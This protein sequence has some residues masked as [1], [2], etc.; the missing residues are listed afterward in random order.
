MIHRTFS[1]TPE[2][3][4][5]FTRGNSNMLPSILYRTFYEISATLSSRVS[6]DTHV[7][8]RENEGLRLRE[9][10]AFQ[11][12]GEVKFENNLTKEGIER[13][14]VWNKKL[15]PSTWIS[16]FDKW[17]MFIHLTGIPSRLTPSRACR[18]TRKVPL[19]RE[20]ENRTTRHRCDDQYGRL[21]RCDSPCRMRIDMGNP[22]EAKVLR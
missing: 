1:E 11:T 20:Q 19:Q 18:T 7:R 12:V 5:A 2:Q 13:H 4:R 14:L 10:N 17:G 9:G 21:H 15:N 22:D 6:K 16:M 3:L 8:H